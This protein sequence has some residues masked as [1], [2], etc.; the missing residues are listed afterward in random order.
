MYN[1]YIKLPGE[2]IID[3]GSE[4]IDPSVYIKWQWWTSNSAVS[5][6]DTLMA[7]FALALSKDGQTWIEVD[8]KTGWDGPIA[9]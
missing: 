2:Y 9:N 4:I 3:V 6:P 5:Y 8:R 1:R 7:D